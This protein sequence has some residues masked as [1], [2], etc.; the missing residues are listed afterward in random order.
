MDENRYDCLWEFRE[1]QTYND[2]PDGCAIDIIMEKFE[3]SVVGSI[4]KYVYLNLLNGETVLHVIGRRR[5]YFLR[6]CSV[7]V[8]Q[9]AIWKIRKEGFQWFLYYQ[10]I[11]LYLS[12]TN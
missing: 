5:P 6:S 11:D 7:I 3:P 1:V 8:A 9:F 4:L 2:N 10:L 12:F